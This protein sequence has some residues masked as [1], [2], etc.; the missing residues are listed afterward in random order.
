MSIQTYGSLFAGVGGIDIGLDSAG[1]QCKF[2]VEWDSNCQQT[3]EYH[4]PTVQRW[5]DICNVNGK[6]LA[7]V[8]L[9]TFGSPCQD[10]SNAGKKAGLKGSRS[11]L[12][13]EAIRVIKEMKES[14][15]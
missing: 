3:L 9:I 5:G 2:Q 6:D 7:P 14:S 4:W 13:F 10:L 15:G 12:F 11:N 1:L 8:D